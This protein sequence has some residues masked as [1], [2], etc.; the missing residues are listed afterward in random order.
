MVETTWVQAGGGLEIE[1]RE[2]TWVLQSET[3]ES[4]LCSRPTS[5]K[6]LAVWPQANCIS[7]PQF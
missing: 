5:T 1:L 2:Q 6:N 4:T 3:A 7:G